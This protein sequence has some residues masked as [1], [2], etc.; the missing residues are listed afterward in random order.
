[1]DNLLVVD[2]ETTGLN[3][4]LHQ[5]FEVAWCDIYGKGG[6]SL[7]LPHSLENAQPE[8]LEVNR[9]YERGLDL[10]FPVPWNMARAEMLGAF[11]DKIFVGS[12]PDFDRRFLSRLL[13]SEPWHHRR[14]DVT[15]MAQVMLGEPV[16]MGMAKT[17]DELNSRYDTKIK[18]PDH[19]A[20]G[21]VRSAVAVYRAVMTWRETVG[22]C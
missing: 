9:Y 18:V 5:V 7:I 3:E 17:V 10:A 21:D 13:G 20:L 15:N 19:T 11:K 2:V 14:V 22:A 12:N 6:R 4:D 1:M 8:A 16:P